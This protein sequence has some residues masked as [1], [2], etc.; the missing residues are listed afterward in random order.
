MDLYEAWT[1]EFFLNGKDNLEVLEDI[2][3]TVRT[4]VFSYGQPIEYT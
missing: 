4:Y 3:L 1:G 2:L